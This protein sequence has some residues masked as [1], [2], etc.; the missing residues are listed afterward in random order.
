ME[1]KHYDKNNILGWSEEEWHKYWFDLYHMAVFKNT[2][3]S[4]NIKAHYDEIPNK[5]L[6]KFKK[7]RRSSLDHDRYIRNRTERLKKQKQYYLDNKD[8]YIQY[9]RNRMALEKRKFINKLKNK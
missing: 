8:K 4:K 3:S 5:L 9:F 7:E 2:Q 6:M 1:I